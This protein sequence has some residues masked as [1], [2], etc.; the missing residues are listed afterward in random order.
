MRAKNYHN[1]AQF[2]I[3]FADLSQCIII[4]YVNQYS[5]VFHHS[6]VDELRLNRLGAEL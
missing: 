5:E 1:T 2:D 4:I 6:F 3:V